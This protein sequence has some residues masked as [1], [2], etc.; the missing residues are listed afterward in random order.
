ML[1]MTR[2]FAG[3]SVDDVDRAR[4]FYTRLGLD[5]RDG[6]MGTVELHLPG[7]GH[8]LVYPKGEAHAPATYTVLDLVVPDVTAALRELADLG[9]EPLRYEGMPQD[10]DGAMRGHGPDIAWFADPAGNVVAV[11]AVD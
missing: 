4:E 8:V 9:I 7:G 2:A 11:P 1:T 6:G 5:V 10:P 3:F